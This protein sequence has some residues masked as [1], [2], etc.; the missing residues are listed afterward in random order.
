M[1]VPLITCQLLPTTITGPRVVSTGG[2]CVCHPSSSRCCTE[3]LC[4]SQ[5]R[6]KIAPM[7]SALFLSHR[8]V[9]R[10]RETL[11]LFDRFQHPRPGSHP[12]IKSKRR[13][14]T[15]LSEEEKPEESCQILIRE[16]IFVNIK[17][18]IE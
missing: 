18:L 5:L 10:N 16:N 17:C 2:V 8:I 9:S 12:S 7:I 15:E 14:E 3:L 11:Y 13:K 1:K 6:A 4:I